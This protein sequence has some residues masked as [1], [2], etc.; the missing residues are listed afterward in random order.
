MQIQDVLAG[1]TVTPPDNWTDDDDTPPTK[2]DDDNDREVKT[3]DENRTKIGG[4]DVD[5][6]H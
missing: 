4:D 3:R 6:E 1:K 5:G 2:N